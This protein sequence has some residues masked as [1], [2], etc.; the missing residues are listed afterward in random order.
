MDLALA[1]TLRTALSSERLEPA[2]FSQLVLACRAAKETLGL[3]PPLI[4][5]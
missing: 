2:R 4:T 3:T 1:H 5:R